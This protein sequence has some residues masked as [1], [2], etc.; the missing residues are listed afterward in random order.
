MGVKGKWS[1]DKKRS[2]VERF[3]A[4]EQVESLAKEIGASRPALYLW[5]KAYRDNAMIVDRRA[6]MT[7]ADIEKAEKRDV[8]IRL[9]S[10]EMDR[11]MYKKK[12]FDLMV[13]TGRI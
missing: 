2:I 7:E 8:V 10:V 1:D 13:E 4:G 11:D 3:L 5:I 9:R 12:L 6:N